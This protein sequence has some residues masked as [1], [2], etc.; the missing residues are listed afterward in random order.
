MPS[1]CAAAA[2][3]AAAAAAAAAGGQVYKGMTSAAR[4]IYK[5][6]GLSGLYRCACIAHCCVC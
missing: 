4:A 6:H 2:V 5:E 3:A 1:A